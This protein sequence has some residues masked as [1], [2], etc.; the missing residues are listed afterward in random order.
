LASELVSSFGSLTKLSEATIEELCQI[1][2]IGQAKAIQ[3]KACFTLANRLSQQ[4]HSIKYRIDNPIHAYNL[5]KDELEKEKRELFAII[6]LDVKGCVI[7]HEIVSI[8]TLTNALIH[9]REVFYPA[10]R[11]KA[12]SIILAHNHPSGDPTPSNEDHQ[13]T[14]KLIEVGKLI[15]IHVND[16]I[17]IGDG[18]YISMRQQGVPF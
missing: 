2:G 5:I 13:I 15:G 17:I 3:L 8:G 18:S 7:N 10:I 1:K 12:M 16:H 14:K 9:P 4:K 6:M 11:H